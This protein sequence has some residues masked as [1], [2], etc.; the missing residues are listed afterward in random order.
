MGDPNYEGPQRKV[1]LGHCDLQNSESPPDVGPTDTL[2]PVL[3]IPDIELIGGITTAPSGEIICTS[4]VKHCVH[5]YKGEE[6][7][8]TFG[9]CG[10]MEDED[11]LSPGG[12]AVNQDGELMVAGHYHLKRFSL[13]GNFIGCIGDYKQP[14]SDLTLHSPLGLA[15]GKEGRIY[16]VETS[17]HR[18]K[19]FNSDFSFRSTFTK[20]DKRLGPGHLNNPMGVATNSKGEVFVA[21][22]SNNDVQVFSPEGEYLYRFKKQ[23]HG[24]GRLA[25]P[26][27]I[28]VD[29]KDYVYIGGGTGTI[30]I[31]ETRDQEAVFVKAFGSHGAEVGQFNAIRCMHVDVRGRLHVGE[32]GTN[33]IQVFQ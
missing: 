5:V 13:D 16:I 27:A 12:V 4:G 21:D 28:A 10:I 2:E 18:V 32:M 11:L 31:F 33:R 30:S 3:V 9:K 26:M 29:A 19:I 17:K 15:L 8:T 1:Q 23:G 7:V 22:L 14:D 20:G 24:L 6:E 25:S